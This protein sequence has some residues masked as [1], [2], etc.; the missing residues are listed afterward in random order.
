ML[1]DNSHIVGFSSTLT[2][3]VY[4]HRTYI[5]GCYQSALASGVLWRQSWGRVCKCG[6]TCTCFLFSVHRCVCVCAHKLLWFTLLLSQ[7]VPP[8]SL[9]APLLL[10]LAYFLMLWVV[11]TSLCTHPLLVSVSKVSSSHFDHCPAENHLLGR[12]SEFFLRWGPL[13]SGR[14]QYL[15]WNLAQHFGIYSNMFMVLLM[16]FPSFPFPVFMFLCFVLFLIAH[17]NAHAI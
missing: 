13:C 8:G 15:P 17:N 6:H 10:M 2:H 12:I 16:L 3:D 4:P 1:R 14:V 7:P 9:P 5:I 11:L